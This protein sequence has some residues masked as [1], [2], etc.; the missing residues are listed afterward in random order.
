MALSL[1][2]IAEALRDVADDDLSVVANKAAEASVIGSKGN[3]GLIL[4][5]WFQ[6]LARGIGDRQQLAFEELPLCLN[7]AANHV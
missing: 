1:E 3:S 7:E 2:A 6:G 4:A 5:H